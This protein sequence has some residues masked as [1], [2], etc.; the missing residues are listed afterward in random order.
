MLYS[1]SLLENVISKS[2]GPGGNS[3]SFLFCLNEVRTYASETLSLMEGVDIYM[4]DMNKK[5][6]FRDGWTLDGKTVDDYT[7]GCAFDVIICGYK[8]GLKLE[9][10]Y[11]DDAMIYFEWR[12][13]KQAVADWFTYVSTNLSRESE[14]DRNATLQIIYNK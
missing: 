3:G 4:T 7:A 5:V 10:F 13:T 11:Y 12:G 6:I 2:E 14:E 8:Y 9:E 1:E